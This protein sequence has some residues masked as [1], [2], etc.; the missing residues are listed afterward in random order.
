MAYVWVIPYDEFVE[1]IDD[2]WVPI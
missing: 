2:D 1:E